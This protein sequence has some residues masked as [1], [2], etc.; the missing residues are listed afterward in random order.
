MSSITHRFDTC[1]FERYAKISLENLLGERYASLINSDRPDLQ[2]P[3]KRIGIEVTR[4]IR[5]NKNVAHALINE[6]A[7]KPITD[8]ESE[9]FRDIRKNGYA[10]GLDN[11]GWVGSLEYNYWALA[12]PM[13]RIIS[14]KVGKVTSG[15]YGDFEE[16]GLYIFTKEDINDADVTNAIDQISELQYGKRQRYHKLFISQIQSLYCCDLTTQTYQNIVIDKDLRRKFYNEALN[17]NL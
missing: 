2:D 4:A 7:G 11:E 10:Y 8:V 14:S 3:E 1:F 13:R 5:E 6:I 16:F 12:H 17:N 9:D 15:F